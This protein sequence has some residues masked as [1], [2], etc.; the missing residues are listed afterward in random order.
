[1]S[2]PMVRAKEALDRERRDTERLMRLIDEATDRSGL[3]D[4]LA[5]GGSEAFWYDDDPVAAVSRRLLL[6]R[7]AALGAI[8]FLLLRRDEEM[9]EAWRRY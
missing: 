9:W 1:V 6:A 5:E 2:D 3:F 7:S 8:A 4:E